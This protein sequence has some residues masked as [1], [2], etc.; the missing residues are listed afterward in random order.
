MES[1]QDFTPVILHRV[2]RA[3]VQKSILEEVRVPAIC[4]AMPLITESRDDK[5]LTLFESG[6]TLEHLTLLCPAC[7]DFYEGITSATT[8]A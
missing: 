1:T 6:N 4:G 3:L 2:P 5:G 8:A 7:Q